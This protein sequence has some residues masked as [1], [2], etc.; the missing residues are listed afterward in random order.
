L[1]PV[2]RA[3]GL[4]LARELRDFQREDVD[5]L[6]KH[7]HKVLVA[8]AP[9]TGKTII[10]LAALQENPHLFPALI[11]CPASVVL[12]WRREAKRWC[13]GRKVDVILDTS[14]PIP[15]ADIL[16]CSWDLVYRRKRKLLE[17]GFNA[18]VMDEAHYAKNPQA[19]R[20]QAVQALAARAH[21]RLPLSG[22]PLVN[23]EDEL[24]VLGRLVGVENP[25]MLRRLLEDVAKDIPP[26][27]RVFVP[28]VLPPRVQKLYDKVEKE[29]SE[30]LA[31]QRGGM[32][33]EDLFAEND[34]TPVKA[35]SGMTAEALVKVGYL[36]RII[37][38][39]KVKAAIEWIQKAVAAGEPVVVFG[40][41]ADV[42]NGIARGLRGMRMKFV[43]VRGGTLKKQRLAAVDAFQAGLVPVFLASKAAKEG[44][45]LTRARHMLFVERWWTPAEE[46][47]GEDRIRRIGQNFRTTIWYLHATDTIDDRIRKIVERKR[48]LMLSKVGGKTIQDVPLSSM[49]KL[50]EKEVPVNFAVAGTRKRPP[51]PLVKNIVRL[52]FDGRRWKEQTA[53]SWA[54][55][56]GY[57]NKR[58]R[59][60]GDGSVV[61]EFE[62]PKLFRRGTFKKV[63]I[64]RDIWAIVGQPYKP[65]VLRSRVGRH[66]NILLRS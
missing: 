56:Q 34:D 23:N 32:R 62:E 16:V 44:I 64:S 15:H 29:F 10:V 50:I 52:V 40:E 53:E 20:S 63:R 33:F 8:N 57:A 42:L 17:R 58:A 47:Q 39:G 37:G 7:D 12:N 1:I 49:Q 9:G 46:E 13:P 54:H 14:S 55:S 43:M 3:F 60:R 41:H 35:S 4:D 28:V 18:V 24:R 36:R 26:K 38:Q 5:F 59:L 51:R 6:K 11:V 22:T 48:A 25:P 45:T 19:L 21:A 27:R 65:K 61:I 66:E 31:Q 30:W 2:R